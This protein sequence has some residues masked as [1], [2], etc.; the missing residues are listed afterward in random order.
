MA[1][2]THQ[3]AFRAQCA[4]QHTSIASAIREAHRLIPGLIDL[5]FAATNNFHYHTATVNLNGLPLAA[6]TA[7]KSRLHVGPRPEPVLLL[8]L[9]GSLEFKSEGFDS[10]I[11]PKRSAIFIPKGWPTNVECT[12]RSLVLM[13]F[14]AQRLLDTA[15]TMLG[16]R[17]DDRLRSAF[18]DLSVVSLHAGEFS[19]DVAFRRLFRIIDAWSDQE[20][21]RD[22]T[23]LDDVFYRTTILAMLPGPFRMAQERHDTQ[24]RRVPRLDRACDYV[25]ANIAEPLTLT[26]LERVSTLSRQD[27]RNA[28]SS[29]YGIEPLAWVRRQRQIF[30]RRRHRRLPAKG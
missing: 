2:S 7:S 11:E 25:M 28:F 4:R 20:L 16:E 19:H 24:S 1:P 8:S 15:Q 26:D 27:L 30:R 23:R 10:S 17:W 18:E 21:L 29:V 14:D 13:R 12:D 3:L 6:V 22:L 5:D 9:G